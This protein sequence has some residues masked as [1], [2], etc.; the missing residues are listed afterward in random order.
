MTKVDF[1][2]VGGN[3]SAAL[4][5]SCQ[6]AAKAWQSGDDVLIFSP[7]KSTISELSERLWA[8][9]ATSFLPHRTTREGP[10]S[11]W[12]CGDGTLSSNPSGNHHDLLINL[13]TGTP[14][15]FGRFDVLCELV[16][17]DENLVASKRHRYKFYKDRG[18][19]LNYHDMTSQF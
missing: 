4:E 16:Y 5:L 10:E 6:L 9:S 15:W 1:Y 2:Q 7:E 8:H 14:E 11:I 3:T 17:G 19:P 12:L 13:A 18:Y